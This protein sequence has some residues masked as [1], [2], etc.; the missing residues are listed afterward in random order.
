MLWGFKESNFAC[1]S[2]KM[3]VACNVTC[4]TQEYTELSESNSRSNNHFIANH[5]AAP[6]LY[7]FIFK[8]GI[9]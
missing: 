3:R 9:A 8:M 5:L 6:H 4:S 7:R 1:G 2:S